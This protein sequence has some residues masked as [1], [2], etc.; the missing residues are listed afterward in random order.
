[1][2]ENDFYRCFKCEGKNV[3]EHGVYC[4]NKRNN[5]DIIMA[6]LKLKHEEDELY[7]EKDNP[8]LKVLA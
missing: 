8:Y 7:K 2:S 6:R 4:P 1:M 3:L 5:A